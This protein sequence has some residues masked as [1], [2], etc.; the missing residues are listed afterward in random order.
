MTFKQGLTNA[1]SHIVFI[2]ALIVAFGLI[3]ALDGASATLRHAAKSQ[4]TDDVIARIMVQPLAERAV[5]TEQ[6]MGYARTAWRYFEN[7]TDPTTKLVNATHNYPSTTVW[8][9]GSYLI[10]LISAERLKLID[11]EAFDERMAGALGSLAKLQLFDG[12]LPNKAYD[13]RNLAMATYNNQPSPRGLGWS[14]LDVARIIVPLTYIAQHYPQHAGAVQGVTGRW[15]MSALVSK[16]EL[17]GSEVKDDKTVTRQ[18]GRV[19]YEQYAAKALLLIGMDTF[20]A[21]QVQRFVEYRSVQGLDIPVDSRRI[22]NGS[23]AFATSEPYLLDGLEFGFDTTSYPLASN[24][25]RAQE[26][27]FA[28]TGHLTAVSEGHMSVAPYFQYS[29]VWGGGTPWAVMNLKGERMDSWRT[30]STKAA[31]AWHALFATDYT[32]QLVASVANLADP[33]KGWAE[34]RYE[35]DGKPNTSTTCNTN[36]IVLASLAYRQFGP[37]MAQNGN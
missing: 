35:K 27:R 12:I 8:D 34:G 19:G 10:A 2:L 31:F 18:E 24:M 11:R 28:E 1:R 20:Q 37:L 9:S 15:K 33:Q 3:F 36:A 6:E 7:N 14:A 21:A 29:T 13:V 22:G 25:Y 5:L 26:R 23:P 16:G 4:E 17:I 32:A 30:L